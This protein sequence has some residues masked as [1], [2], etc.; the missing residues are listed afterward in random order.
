MTADPSAVP[1]GVLDVAE[2]AAVDEVSVV[3]AGEL[4]SVLP[5]Y[6]PTVIAGVDDAEAAGL[7]ASVLLRSLP[8]SAEVSLVDGDG[9]PDRRVSSIDDLREIDVATPSWVVVPAADARVE[10]IGALYAADLLRSETIE[11]EPLSRR[12]AVL[13]SG[14]WSNRM[15]ID[16]LL[17]ST[18]L[19]WRTERMNAVDRNILRVGV[20]ELRHTDLATGI[21][22]D[23]AVEIAKR[24]STARSAA[25]VNGVLDTI[26]KER[27]V[28]SDRR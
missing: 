1:D 14:A 16:E 11:T 7:V 22:V 15:E 25:F 12:G 9:G 10:A 19:G 26:A 28:P 24:F 2:V 18:A 27:W 17:D 3:D 8:G 23:Q 4:P 5:L 13:A 21:I 20:F 6:V